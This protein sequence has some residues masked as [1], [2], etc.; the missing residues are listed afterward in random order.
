MHVNRYIE[1]ALYLTYNVYINVCICVCV[2]VSVYT[3]LRYK[4][5][6]LIEICKNYFNKKLNNEFED[7]VTFYEINFF[8]NFDNLKSFK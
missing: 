1:N 2:Y 6:H 5:S 4:I 3:Y 8:L 7:I